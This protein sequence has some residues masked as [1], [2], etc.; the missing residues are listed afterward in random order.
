MFGA[1]KAESITSIYQYYYQAST[2]L[3]T[4]LNKDEV[5]FLDLREK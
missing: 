4:P 1:E 2:T 3:F 5:M